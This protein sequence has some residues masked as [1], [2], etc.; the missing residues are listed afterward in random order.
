MTIGFAQ[1]EFRISIQYNWSLKWFSM[2]DFFS[3]LEEQDNVLFSPTSIKTA[4]AM[5]YEGAAG[6]TQAEFEK[7]F[8]FSEDNAVFLK[9]IEQ[10][11]EVAEISN[12]VWLQDKFEILASY[13][14]KLKQNF[15]SEPYRTDLQ[16]QSRPQVS[17]FS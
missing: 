8:N 9:E 6:N 15:D 16:N 14:K 7:V 11:K 4:F 1:N 13:V 3:E 2:F 10:L 17:A 12:S 5:A